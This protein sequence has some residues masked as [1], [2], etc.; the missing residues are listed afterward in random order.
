MEGGVGGGTTDIPLMTNFQCMFKQSSWPV[1]GT[2]KAWEWMVVFQLAKLE[3]DNVNFEYSL[4][5]RLD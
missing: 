3:F 5:M 1:C 4:A 2:V